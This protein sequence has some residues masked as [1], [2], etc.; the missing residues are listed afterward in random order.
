MNRGINPLARFVARIDDPLSNP[1]FRRSQ[2]S[3]LPK[4]YVRLDNVACPLAGRLRLIQQIQ[5]LPL[6]FIPTLDS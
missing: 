4:V 2:A 3:T 5:A 1:Y 6:P